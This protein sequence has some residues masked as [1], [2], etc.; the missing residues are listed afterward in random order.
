MMNHHFEAFEFLEDPFRE[1]K[2]PVSLL[3][4]PQLD[5]R[6]ASAA[7]A[8]AYERFIPIA[9]IHVETLTPSGLHGGAGDHFELGREIRTPIEVRYND[10][11]GCYVLV[12]GVRRLRQAKLNRQTHI[13]AFVEP[14]RCALLAGRRA[15][16]QEALR[17]RPDGASSF[18]HVNGAGV[19]A[20]YPSYDVFLHCRNTKRLLGRF[21]DAYMAWQT[22]NKKVESCPKISIEE[23]DTGVVIG[24]RDGPSVLLA[25]EYSLMQCKLQMPLKAAA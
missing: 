12:D 19:I 23:S 1:D 8:C 3:T 11:E 17:I 22:M 24:L 21:G 10:K 14:D 25:L 18:C 2:L 15:I 9:R 20:D 13:L 7:L 16:G 6:R 4:R 5:R